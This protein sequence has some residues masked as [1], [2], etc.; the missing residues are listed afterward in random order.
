MIRPLRDAHRWIFAL[1]AVAV[2]ALLVAALARPR[3]FLL[4]DSPP[5]GSPTVVQP[6]SAPPDD[7]TAAPAEGEDSSP[8]ESR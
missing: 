3:G 4:L 1:I 6:G 7:S 2:A 5:L 8:R